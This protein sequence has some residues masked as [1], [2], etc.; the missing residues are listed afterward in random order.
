[1][2]LS[3][4]HASCRAGVA[5]STCWLS[6]FYMNIGNVILFNCSPS[7]SMCTALVVQMTPII[8]G[9][10]Q[11]VRYMRPPLT[12][13]PLCMLPRPLTRRAERPPRGYRSNAGAAREKTPRRA[14]LKPR[15]SFS[16]PLAAWCGNS[17][18]SGSG[19]LC[20]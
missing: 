2:E 11:V 20:F 14:P 17:R 19:L 1:M 18:V 12:V 5:L 8:L 9:I 7:G 15:A 13:P 16:A 6:D 10:N 3:D 4:I